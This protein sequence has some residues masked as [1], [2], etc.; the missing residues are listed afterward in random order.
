MESKKKIDLVL[1]I[2][3]VGL[4]VTGVAL[5]FDASY[6]RASHEI[7]NSKHYGNKQMIYAVIGIVAMLLTMASL[8]YWKLKNFAMVFLV[9]SIVSLVLVFVPGL[10]VSVN[11]AKRWIDIA[12]QRIQPSEF[13]KLGLI[14]YLAA[15][16]SSK[17]REVRDVK[18]GLLPL[19]LPV[20]AVG[21]LVVKEDMGTAIVVIATTL[22][23]IYMSGAKGKHVWTI[24]LGCT[25]LGIGFILAEP[26]R[27]TRLLTFLDPFKDAQ[28]TGYQVCQSLIS[29]GSGGLFGMGFCEGRQKLLFMP[30][31]HTDF[32][33][34]VLGQEKG[35]LG[36]AA[37][38]LAFL[39][40]GIRGI[41]IAMKTKEPFGKLLAGG[42]TVMICGQALLNMAVVT[43][44]IPTTGVPLPFISYGGS[45]LLM[46]L[47]CVGILLGISKYPG[48]SNTYEYEN[49]VN[50]R[51]N[52]R[53]RVPGDKHR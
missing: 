50:R 49:R 17:K 42:I 33:F 53:T 6:A 14:I 5:V 2:L 19:L 31:E 32:I 52:R 20:A 22:A 48:M 30:E 3:T 13:A 7:G 16:L 41:M 38:S 1:F 8:K 21:I 47:I 35:L 46:N 43:S 44:S 34:S 15:F 37:L 23:M 39:G 45:S 40:F 12:G 4:V 26:F 18:Q 28:N 10:G 36:T 27:V 11:G 29:L 51:R 9:L 25:I 24:I